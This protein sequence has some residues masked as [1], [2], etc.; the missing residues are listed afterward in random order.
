MKFNSRHKPSVL[1]L[2][3]AAG[4][5]ALQITNVF[6]FEIPTTSS[7]MSGIWWN[8]NESGWG[9]QIAQ[10]YGTMLVSIYTFDSEKKPIWYLAACPVAGN[11][12]SGDLLKVSGGESLTSKWSGASKANLKVGTLQLTFS[13]TDT[14]SLSATVEG[15]AVVKPI[16]RYVFAAP[17]IS[18]GYSGGPFTFNGTRV[19]S[20]SFKQDAVTNICKAT[21]NVTNVNASPASAF[22]QFDVMVGG[23]AVGVTLYTTSALAAGATAESVSPILG[24]GKFL[25]CGE[26]DLKF[27]AAG[28]S[29]FIN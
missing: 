1:R 9:T 26:F 2:I 7:P 20:I 13:D 24:S 21:I 27:N 10:Q 14:G 6:A 18:S 11:G 12:C 22:L 4:F 5:T 8:P 17:P 19:N 3:A 29:V 23:I 28:S 25:A 16:S 15:A